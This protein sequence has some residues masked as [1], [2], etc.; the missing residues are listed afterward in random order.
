LAREKN[1]RRLAAYLLVAATL[2]FALFPIFWV[3][4]TSFKSQQEWFVRPIH[5]LPYSP[6]LV[7][8]ASVFGSATAVRSI[9]N[10]LIVT[11]SATVLAFLIGFPAAYVI[12]RL[13]TGRFSLF[14]LPLIVRACPPIV[15]AIPLLVFYAAF[16]LTDTLQA[17]IPVYA[18]T[19]VFYFIWLVKPFIDAVPHEV[20][21]AAMVD[22]VKRWRLPFSVILPIVLGG[23]A[24]ATIFVFILNWTEFVLVL[25][26]TR[27]DARTI[28]VQMTTVTSLYSV[29]GYGQQA[30]VSTIS[31]IPF[32][33]VAYF[34][35]KQLL[36]TFYFGTAK[37]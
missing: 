19:T 22:G 18:G 30:V 34:L 24:A 28:P 21:E 4:S 27:L 9:Y 31:L 2:F 15:F 7:N 26:L 32:L 12:S 5:W 11:F 16:G 23:V 3:T 14:V 35:Q 6:S 37:G 29:Q 17:L 36:R 1:N 20:E 8:Y 13:R 25:T 10:S 33:A